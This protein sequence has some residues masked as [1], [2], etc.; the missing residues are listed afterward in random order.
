MDR[1]RCYEVFL[2]YLL[3]ANAANCENCSESDKL[4]VNERD[5]KCCEAVVGDSEVHTTDKVCEVRL[6]GE[7]YELDEVSEADYKVWEVGEADE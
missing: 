5:S 6:K 4:L 1:Y 7:I 3:V 2:Q